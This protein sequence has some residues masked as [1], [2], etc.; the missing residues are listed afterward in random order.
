MTGTV[1]RSLPLVAALAL[2][3]HLRAG[4][5]PMWRNDPQRSGLSEE[6]LPDQLHLLWTRD[7]P[8]PAPAWSDER[9]GFDLAPAPVIVGKTLL[10]GDS[11]TGS[12]RALNTDTGAERWRFW[13]N[14]PVRLAPAVSD[15]RVFVASDDGHLYSLALADGSL[16]WKF[17]A[18]LKQARLLANEHLSSMWPVRGGPVVADGRVYFAAGVWPFMGA[19]IYAL[20]TESGRELWSNDRSGVLHV[21]R[22][23]HM[24]DVYWGTWQRRTGSKDTT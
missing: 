3:P 13:A 5:W 11:R 10:L 1:S 21:N 2:V 9:L 6:E 18:G 16:Q 23:S 14:G 12:L 19:P 8:K 15:G 20:D 22:P 7:L 4:D 24:Y 17:F